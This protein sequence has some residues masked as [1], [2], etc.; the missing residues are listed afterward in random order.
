MTEVHLSPRAAGEV[1]AI[2]RWNE[3]Q[4]QGLGDEFLSELEEFLEAVSVS[5][6]M[7]SPVVFTRLSS[8]MSAAMNNR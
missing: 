6:R 3:G 5:P 2:R 4:L 7:Y 8:N 1:E